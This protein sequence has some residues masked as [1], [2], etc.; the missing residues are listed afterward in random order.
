MRH[1]LNG[2]N[3][4]SEKQDFQTNQ[5]PSTGCW[6][7]PCVVYGQ[8]L[9]DLLLVFY[10]HDPLWPTVGSFLSLGALLSLCLDL[11]VV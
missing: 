2:E 8:H 1:C 5:C 11:L 6:L 9:S 7:H 10:K 4:D 3:D